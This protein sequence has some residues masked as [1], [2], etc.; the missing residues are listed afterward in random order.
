[1]MQKILIGITTFNNVDNKSEIEKIYNMSGIGVRIVDDF[2]TD[3]LRDYLEAKQIEFE[4][5]PQKVG[6]PGLGRNMIL[7][8][9]IANEYQYVTFID[10]DDAILDD[11]LLEL[12]GGLEAEYSICY[13]PM[14]TRGYNNALIPSESANFEFHGELRKKELLSKDNLKL[15]KQLLMGSGGRIYNVGLIKQHNL[16]YDPNKSGQDTLFNHQVFEHANV[17]KYLDVSKPFYIYN[18]QTQSLSNNYNLEIM[19]GRLELIEQIAKFPYAIHTCEEYATKSFH[20]YT[21]SYMMSEEDKCELVHLLST[22]TNKEYTYA[23]S[24]NYLKKKELTREF[25]EGLNIILVDCEIEISDKPLFNVVRVKPFNHLSQIEEYLVYSKTI[26]LDKTVLAV[27]EGVLKNCIENQADLIQPYYRLEN[28]LPVHKLDEPIYHG[29]STTGFVNT[30]TYVGMVFKTKYLCS[31]EFSFGGYFE[32]LVKAMFVNSLIPLV[33]KTDNFALSQRNITK[34]Y[35]NA[36]IRTYNCSFFA[37]TRGMIN[38][39]SNLAENGIV[40]GTFIA[41]NDF[42]CNSNLTSEEQALIELQMLEFSGFDGWY[43]I[44]EDNYLV[45]VVSCAAVLDFDK[46]I[47]MRR[48][49]GKG[50]YKTNK[51]IVNLPPSIIFSS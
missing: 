39:Y 12:V 37:N 45:D 24:K 42:E 33:V 21:R 20:R 11:N 17:I 9:A 5:P 36:I 15:C 29:Y 18:I 44:D 30:Y 43:L 48:V 26:I 10:G 27:D 7:E 41:N 28:N 25:K 6:A 38:P 4:T 47:C 22:F 40:K 1:M 46:L 16:R 3:G 19:K 50:K 2:S 34:R 13:S 31:V 51:P 23:P 14:L 49:K 8:Y 35:R 32:F